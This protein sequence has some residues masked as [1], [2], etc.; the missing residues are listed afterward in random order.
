MQP[1]ALEHACILDIVDLLPFSRSPWFLHH[2]YS[3]LMLLYADQSVHGGDD[4]SDDVNVDINVDFGDIDDDSDDFNDD[5]AD[6]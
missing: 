5:I 1:T 3:L 2:T 4:S 6:N